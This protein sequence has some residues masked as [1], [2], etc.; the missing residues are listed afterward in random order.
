MSDVACDSCVLY[1]DVDVSVVAALELQVACLSLRLL[2][3]VCLSRVYHLCLSGML[4][5][6]LAHVAHVSL[7]RR[8]HAHAQ[9]GSGSERSAAG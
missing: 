9:L 1:V 6:S 3:S 8:A 5:V 2:L 7:T 4:P